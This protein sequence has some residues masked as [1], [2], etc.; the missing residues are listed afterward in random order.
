MPLTHD[1]EPVS[2]VGEP[3]VLPPVLLQ[4]PFPS[5]FSSFSSGCVA[6]SLFSQLSELRFSAT[7]GFSLVHFQA[8]PP[9][10]TPWL[11]CHA[12]K[13]RRK[14]LHNPDLHLWWHQDGPELGVTPPHHVLTPKTSKE[15]SRFGQEEE[16]KR[17]GAERCP[18]K[19]CAATP[20]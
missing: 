3:M 15:G 7:E 9:Q 8:H 20:G 1:W 19:I 2:P 16:W 4:P 13:R 10:S 5:P 11:G 18:T 12:E 6:N 14:S 17:V